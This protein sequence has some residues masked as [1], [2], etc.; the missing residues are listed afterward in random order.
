VVKGLCGNR[1]EREQAKAD[2]AH[3]DQV[4]GQR[5]AME[6]TARGSDRIAKANLMAVA[7][8][9]RR[10]TDAREI[11]LNDSPAEAVRKSLPRKRS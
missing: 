5:E 2:D 1:R 7:V 10:S 3:G 9:I 4:F 8:V 11:F 6:G